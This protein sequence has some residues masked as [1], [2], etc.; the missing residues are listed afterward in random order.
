MVKAISQK[1]WS[2]CFGLMAGGCPVAAIVAILFV[3]WAAESLAAEPTSE[4]SPRL[5]EVLQKYPKADLNG[6]GVLTAEEARTARQQFQK[7]RANKA[8][9]R[10][11]KSSQAEQGRPGQTAPQPT[12]ANVQYGPHERNVLDFWKADSQKPTALVVFIHGGGFVGGDKSKADSEIIRACLDAGVSFMA[13]NYR[14]RQHAP[15]QDI[16]RDAARAI[17]FIR[18]H[19]KEYNID[20]KRIASYGGSAGAG[21][22]LWLAVHDDLADPK[23]TDTVLRQSSRLSAAGCFNGQATYDM[24]EW[25]KIIG[26]F[27]EEWMRSPKERIEFYHF[28]SETDVETPEGR[29]I[30]DD[31]SMLRQI[32]RD[33]PPIFM[34]CG[35]AD[36]EPKNRGQYVHHPRHMAAVKKQCEAAKIECVTVG[37]EDFPNRN[38]LLLEFLFKH[39]KVK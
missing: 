12:F 38:K 32:T 24:T 4:N 16:L 19:A 34:A 28:K 31:C 22:S 9:V 21:T 35:L 7:E 5:K 2:K 17:Q 3:A 25:E 8:G 15:I 30:L 1:H 36:E 27:Q 10:A 13:I 26:P 29:K 18:D 20:P 6:D 11:G 14:F 39:L 23:S 37:R 33:D